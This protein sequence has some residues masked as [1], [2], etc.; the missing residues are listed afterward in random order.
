LFAL[1]LFIGLDVPETDADQIA[2]PA[3]C[4]LASRAK[5]EDLAGRNAPTSCDLG[6]RHD[7]LPFCSLLAG[8]SDTV[9]A[10]AFRKCDKDH[11]RA[12]NVGRRYRSPECQITGADKTPNDGA[13]RRRGVAAVLRRKTPPQWNQGGAQRS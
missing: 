10:K 5:V 2:D 4:Q 3:V 12:R 7:D 11:F 6:D 1:P 9:P 13:D 8:H